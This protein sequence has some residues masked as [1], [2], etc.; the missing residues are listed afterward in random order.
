MTLVIIDFGD[1]SITT[2]KLGYV[3]E[4]ISNGANIKVISFNDFLTNIMSNPYS[5]DLMMQ[6][7]NFNTLA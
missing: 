7:M 4:A 1:F 3:E 2:V 6:N 5:N